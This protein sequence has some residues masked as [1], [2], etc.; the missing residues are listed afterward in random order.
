M[1][2]EDV[3]AKHHLIMKSIKRGMDEIKEEQGSEI[4]K[5]LSKLDEKDLVILKH[6]E[7]SLISR[8]L[9]RVLQEVF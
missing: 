2:P 1:T 5:V 6:W 4:S 8:A 9:H 3:S 7:A